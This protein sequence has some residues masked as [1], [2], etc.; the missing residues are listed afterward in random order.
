MIKKFV[1]VI[2]PLFIIAI[3]SIGGYFYWQHQNRYPSTDDA[4][5]QAD[6]INV[7]SRASG[8]VSEI[9][10]RNE[11]HVQKGQLLFTIDPAPFTI[12]LNKA[13]AQRDAT[14]QKIQAADMAVKSARATVVER[15]A[16]LTHTRLETKRI[17]TLMKKQFVSRS[18]GDLA[19]KNLHVAE[20]AL[21]AAQNQLEEM[22][23]KRGELGD[24][25]AQLRLAQAAVEKAKL[26]LQY[27]R[28]F[29]PTSGYI[30]NF[31]LRHGDVVSAYQPLF[32][33]IED[34]TW[35]AQANFKE[36]QLARIHTGEQAT[37]KLDM[38]PHQI[39]IGKVVDVNKDSGSSFSL[40]PP[41][42]ASGNWVKA[43]QRFPVKVIITQRKSG[44]PLR[45]GASSTVTIDTTSPK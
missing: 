9:D 11:E 31:N 45:L 30:A 39:F 38:Y 17:L 18:D 2:L 10:V 35:W 23:E 34:Q 1:K 8:T 20:A 19:I 24:K 21:N 13:Q 26:D 5:I 27:T 41:E 3:L 6:V 40:L 12:E 44:Y 14:R 25:N 4:Y 33:L 28:V 37:I 7:A 32:A 22:I 43:T 42:N 16:E 29:A 15:K 36:T